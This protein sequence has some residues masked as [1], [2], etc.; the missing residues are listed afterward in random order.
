MSEFGPEAM[1]IEWLHDHFAE[2]DGLKHLRARRRGRVVTIESGPE[3]DAVQHA[4]FR[5]NTVYL[6]LL[7][8]PARGGRWDGTPFRDTV[9]HLMELLEARFPWTLTPIAAT[10]ADGTSD[11]GY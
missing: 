9:E 3:K 10:K 4:R 11:P 6:W 5:R 8:M 2:V 7:E 1:A